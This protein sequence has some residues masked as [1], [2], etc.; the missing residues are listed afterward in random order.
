MNLL[1]NTFL[2]RLYRA[3]KLL[4]SACILYMLGIGYYALKQRE[5][6]P[7]LLYGMY[8]LKEKPQPVYSTYS[9]TG[10]G[11]EIKYAK[12]RDAQRELISSTL[13]NAVPL[14]DSGTLS[15]EKAIQYKQWLM[16]Y[17]FDVRMTG[18]NAMTVYRLNCNYDKDGKINVLTKQTVYTYAAE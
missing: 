5:E 12:L 6:F 14:M 1:K 7:F 8:S 17:C 18:E 3:D 9:I 10:G 2:F 16:N 4:F 15:P 13:T 11:Q